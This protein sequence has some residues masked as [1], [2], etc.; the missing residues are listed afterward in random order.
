MAGD[1]THSIC[2]GIWVVHKTTITRVRCSRPR[3]RQAETTL[4]STKARTVCQG[5]VEHPE[6]TTTLQVQPQIQ[7]RKEK[8]GQ[9]ITDKEEADK[10]SEW[11]GTGLV[12]QIN[13]SHHSQL[14]REILR[15]LTGLRSR[16]LCLAKPTPTLKL[17]YTGTLKLGTTCRWRKA[18]IWIWCSTTLTGQVLRDLQTTPPKTSTNRTIAAMLVNL[19]REQIR[20]RKV[21]EK[22]TEFRQ[23]K[24]D[25]D[26][27]IRICDV[28][29]CTK[30]TFLWTRSTYNRRSNN[31][32]T[33]IDKI[34]RCQRNSRLV[35]QSR[36]PGKPS[37]VLAGLIATS[38]L[39]SKLIWLV[40]EKKFGWKWE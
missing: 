24:E 18:K 7:I 15:W 25:T 27:R 28:A 36:V 12:M 6:L 4:F 37:L 16:G 19:I 20:I 3:S 33:N 2:L 31:K 11:S 1:P 34:I 13:S 14:N 26:Q 10:F 23:G 8:E 9:E 5:I 35:S 38:K 39:L 22:V 29:I 30:E 40:C 17:R 21:Q 32:A